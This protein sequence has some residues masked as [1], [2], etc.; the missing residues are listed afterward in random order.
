M[1]D[2][3]PPPSGAGGVAQLEP[4]VRR[5][6]GAR[7]ADPPTVEDLTQE[8]L[9][10]IVAARGRLDASALGPYAIVTARNLVRSWARTEKRHQ[11]L[12]P[13]LVDAR[14]PEDPAEQAMEAEDRRL[15]AA[16]LDQLSAADREAL[17]AHDVEGVATTDLAAQLG[18]SP[19]AVT[20]RLVRARARLRVEYLLGLRRAELPTPAC[21]PVLLALSGGDKRR[22]RALGVGEHL[23]ICP[24]CAGLSEPLLQRGRPLA[25]LW[26][27]LGLERAIGWVR[28]Q[29]REHPVQTA[30][31]GAMAVVAVALIALSLRD[32]PSRPVLFVPGDPPIEL[33][34][35]EPLAPYAGREVRAE[36]ATVESVPTQEGFWVGSSRSDRVWVDLDGGGP[37][38]QPVTPGQRVSF[39]GRLVANH[40]E[41]PARLGLAAPADVA[42]LEGQGFHISI[43]EETLQLGGGPEAPQ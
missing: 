8:T 28:H 29:G 6:I 12:A 40:A 22:Q 33:S 3:H 5:V 35:S 37:I 16:A 13:G 7:V 18:T 39:V 21:K 42:Q 43:T 11:R 10:R 32:E 2:R 14:R 34:G 24:P 36:G 17:V 31:T 26:P 30:A 25:A 4:L 20:V 23:L 19:G 1:S 27:A 15:L 41:L 9:A 38:S